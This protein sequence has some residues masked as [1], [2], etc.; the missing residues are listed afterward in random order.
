VPKKRVIDKEYIIKA[1]RKRIIDIIWKIFLVALLFIA[2]T[3]AWFSTQKD[4]RISNLRG[5]VDVAEKMEISLD[6]KT[7]YRRIDLS[8]ITD[9]NKTPLQAA[10]ASRNAASGNT[11]PNI[12]PME[13]LPVSTVGSTGGTYVPF[14]EGKSRKEIPKGKDGEKLSEVSILREI[15]ECD[16]FGTNGDEERQDCGYFAFDIYIKNM[17]RDDEPDVLQLNLNSAVEV[18]KE[19]IEKE[20]I[21]EGRTVLRLYE[22]D[23]ASG[24]QNTIRVG[25]A[26]YE[27]TVDKDASQKQV[28]DVTKGSK[29]S[30]FVIWEPNAPYHVPYIVKNNNKLSGSGAKKFDNGDIL[31]T[32]ALTSGAVGAGTIQNVYNTDSP[33]LG[34]QNTLQTEA[35]NINE[36]EEDYRIFTEDEKPIN[37]V[38]IDGEELTIEANKISRLRVYVWVE[39]Q[40][41]DCINYASYGGG[42]EM[43]L[44]FT[45]DDA[46]GEVLEED[47]EER[48]D[49]GT[50]TE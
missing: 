25:L 39:G 27:D 12:E 1:R 40:D 44:G 42:I 41:I 50:I 43:D 22:G 36:G 14:Y 17:S 47:F 6:A 13:L 2:T 9:D 16:E 28:L 35:T 29:I 4:I 15:Q 19:Q 10:V 23:S 20:I 30:K 38:D 18:L 26:L 48:E 31:T 5:R 37:L 21:V 7:W 33:G 49:E 46:I 11:A 8:K 34:K 24:L 32:Y 45:K 3:Y